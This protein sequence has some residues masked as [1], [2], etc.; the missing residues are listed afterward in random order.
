VIHQSNV[1]HGVH[2]QFPPPGGLAS[3]IQL[4]PEMLV[5]D[6]QLLHPLTLT[7]IFQLQSQNSQHFF[8]DK[9]TASL[10]F[11][12]LICSSTTIPFSVAIVSFKWDFFRDPSSIIE[13]MNPMDPMYQMQL[14]NLP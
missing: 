11:N 9:A 6:F 8:I 4:T 12:K 3:M 2:P 5:F 13:G 1:I 7:N 10:Q 14:A